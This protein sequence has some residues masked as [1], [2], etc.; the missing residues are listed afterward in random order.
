MA[1]TFTEK[2]LLG[3]WLIE[4]KKGLAHI[5]NIRRGG[6]GGFQ[7]FEGPNNQLNHSISDTNLDA[8]KKKVENRFG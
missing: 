4:V 7:F 3:G 1:L 2:D 8:L 6:L 5:G